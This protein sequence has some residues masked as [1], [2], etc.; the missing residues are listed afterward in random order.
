MITIY[1]DPHLGLNLGANTTPAS[2]KALRSFI[3]MNLNKIIDQARDQEDAIICGGDF[4]HTYQNSEE[5]LYDSLWAASMTDKILAGNHDVVNIADKKGTLDIVATVLDTR[6]V[7]CKFG[8]SS[9]RVVP[10]NFPPDKA[11]THLYLVPHHSTQELFETTLDAARVSAKKSIGKN[12]LIAHCN[13][14]SKFIKDQVMLNLTQ[15]K[16]AYLLD[17]FDYIVLG[18][19]HNYREDLDGRVIVVGSP[20]PTAFG[21]ISDKFVLRFL[22][23]CKPYKK[24]TWSK[25]HYL[26]A[27]WQEV[28]AK[29]SIEHQWIKVTGEISPSQLHDLAGVVR[30]VWKGG[31]PFAVKSDVKILTGD[32]TRSAYHSATPERVAEIIE[33]EL[34]NSP[35]LYALWKEITN[36][37]GAA[38]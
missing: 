6:V 23:G 27:D 25:A 14:D 35:E 4:Y 17:H 30:D 24:R 26:E 21:D 28:K 22:D 37:Q 15:R 10:I 8:E 29:Q 32:A 13:Y 7:P 1:S 33:L 19:E 5:V 38:P 9:Y 12:V 31:K 36:D 20:H 18:H 11:T 16:A 34:K 3:Q 2:R